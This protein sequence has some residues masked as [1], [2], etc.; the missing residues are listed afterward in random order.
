MIDVASF[1]KALKRNGQDRSNLDDK[2]TGKAKSVF[3]HRVAKL[4]GKSREISFVKAKF[5]RRS[6][7]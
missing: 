4:G 1:N 6:F 2:G 5:Q 7:A 3:N